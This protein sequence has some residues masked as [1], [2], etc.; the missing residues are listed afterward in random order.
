[1]EKTRF[2]LLPAGGR[3]VPL[4]PIAVMLLLGFSFLPGHPA[5]DGDTD[6]PGRLFKQ[7]P[8]VDTPFQRGCAVLPPGRIHYLLGDNPDNWRTKPPPASNSARVDLEP[9]HPSD[10]DRLTYASFLG[11]EAW[12][13]GYALAVDGDGYIY[14]AGD[15]AS[16]HFPLQSPYQPSRE[17]DV[18]LF[19]A[20]LSPD[21]QTLVWA[22]YIGG[23]GYDSLD[24]TST[25][26]AIALDSQRQVVVAGI[27]GSADFPVANAY[28][29]WYGGQY[30]AFVLKL[31]AA[32]SGLVFSTYLGSYG[33][34]AAGFVAI[35]PADSVYVTG[36]TT[37]TA[38]PT[39][40]AYQTSRRGSRDA[41]VAKF[42]AAGALVYSTYLGGTSEEAGY[43]IDVDDSGRAYVTGETMSGTFPVTVDAFQP[44]LKG[45]TDAYLARLGPQGNTLEYG[46]FL[47]GN[48]MD[49]GYSLVLDA[50][51]RAHVLGGSNSSAFPVTPGAYQ[52]ANG[53]GQDA[54]VCRF[55]PACTGLEYATFLGGYGAEYGFGL[56][57][58]GNGAACVT[59]YTTSPNFPLKGPLPV[60]PGKGIFASSD[61]GAH[62]R[63]A[64]LP[65][66]VSYAQPV[67]MAVDPSNPARACLGTSGSGVY[68]TTDGG[69]TW[70]PANTG[71]SS[72]E[73]VYSLA[74]FPDNPQVVYLTGFSTHIARSSDGGASWTEV[75]DYSTPPFIN[76]LVIHP[77]NS[78]ILCGAT[79]FDGFV[80]STDGGVNWT[81]LNAG[82]PQSIPVL[83]QLV[84]DPA[85]PARLFVGSAMYGV[86][87]TTDGGT[88]WTEINQGL[89]NTQLRSLAL[90]NQTPPVLLAG[91][92]RGGLSRSTDGGSAW[93]PV[94]A[95]F[96]GPL[97]VSPL[98]VLTA[99]VATVYAGADVL[100]D[101]GAVFRSTDA[102]LTWHGV[103]QAGQVTALAVAPGDPGRVY[104]G[105]NSTRNA[106][107][108]LLNPSGTKMTFSSLL[109]AG[110]EIGTAAAFDAAGWPVLAGLAQ[111][112]AFPV[113]DALQPAIGEPGFP[114][115]YL[116]RVDLSSRP[117]DVNR[118]GLL[119]VV[120]LALVDLWLAGIPVELDQAVADLDG[121]GQV[122]TADSLLLAQLLADRWSLDTE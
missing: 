40:S 9:A 54:F 101:S 13:A 20:K 55:D 52:G 121:N 56:A 114:D 61:G 97:T 89:P 98:A 70:L 117:G 90:I 106:F 32:G 81:P 10:T 23:N 69:A 6:A 46:T 49:S 17:G 53:G 48:Y 16:D 60:L 113:V 120:D 68:R 38:F 108:S 4:Y 112:P 71:L 119:N 29:N 105:V 18:D 78:Q 15:T 83:E 116:V 104:A 3:R 109:G 103:N 77:G 2:T 26:G 102:G 22:T 7:Q 21:G 45:S 82:L 110:N 80:K 44:T 115:A 67:E 34:D 11:G 93:T 19:V 24:I 73:N 84:M 63:R 59:G 122:Q 96:A 87:R 92:L 14:L 62:F 94:G 99:P 8:A 5:A 118:D 51:H 66:L 100:T 75:G 35:G 74:Y 12:D 86:F 47:G 27:T 64:E 25:G 1:M 36:Q 91:T 85:N 43:G 79:S 111:S 76:A 88:S 50:S 72:T 30:D 37:S 107:V 41:F 65:G 33:V 39:L 58:D 28:D 31:N 42:D 57:L 95:N